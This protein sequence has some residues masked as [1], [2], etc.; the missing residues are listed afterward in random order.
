MLKPHA[1]YLSLFF[2]LMIRRPPR[3][4]LFPYTTLFRSPRRVRSDR[5]AHSRTARSPLPRRSEEHTSELQSRENLVCRLLL[6]KKK[7]K[8][9]MRVDGTNEDGP[10]RAVNRS[11]IEIA[12]LASYD[13][14]VFFFLMI[15]RPPRSTLFPYT[16][17]FRSLALGLVRCARHRVPAGARSGAEDRKSTRLNSSHVKISYAVFCL[18][19]KKKMT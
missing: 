5:L 19:K 18:K 6:E 17:L 14:S 1:A 9:C 11:V 10:Q 13:P 2:F 3:S 8:H 15:R 4:T 12:T 16:T 7:N